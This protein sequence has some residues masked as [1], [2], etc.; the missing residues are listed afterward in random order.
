LH[1]D[2]RWQALLSKA[3]LSD[4]QLAAIDFQVSI[5]D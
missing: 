4:A 3:G 1:D 5:P 2:P